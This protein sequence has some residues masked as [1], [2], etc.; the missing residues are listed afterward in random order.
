VS[1]LSLEKF[2]YSN[3]AVPHSAPA[4]AIPAKTGVDYAELL[5]KILTSIER[6]VLV[7]E[8]IDDLAF[9]LRALR[10][11]LNQELKPDSPPEMPAQAA[12]RLDTLLR[13]YRERLQKADQERAEDFRKILTILNEAFGQLSSGSE[14]SSSR[15]K[16]LETSLQ[17]AAKSENL[18]LLKTQLS[19]TLTYIRRESEQD[20]RKNT[21][22]LLALNQH[23]EFAY[24]AANRFGSS[25]SERS[26]AILEL[27]EAAKREPGEMSSYIALFVAD[28]ASSL[29]ARHGGEVADGLLEEVA[30]RALRPAIPEGRIYRWSES[31]LIVIWRSESGLP[32]FRSAIA[33]SCKQLFDYR[34]FVGT[35]VATFNVPLRSVVLAAEGNPE[36]LVQNLDQFVEGLVAR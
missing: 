22:A 19:D 23:I 8:A 12:A 9:D 2:L 21:N 24:K 15:L 14:R 36:D 27:A 3:Q 6:S 4:P 26:E 30:Q 20:A 5:S 11:E 33:S 35:R 18:R 1:L 32:A 34:A 25:L 7:G 16:Q 17:R 31:S 29:R 28:Y 10:D 13:I